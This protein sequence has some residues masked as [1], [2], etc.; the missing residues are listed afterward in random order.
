MASGL[1]ATLSKR[2]ALVTGGASGLGRATAARLARAGAKVVLLDLPSSAGAAVAKEL[3][4]PSSA[5]FAAADVTSEA[6]VRVAGCGGRL[7]SRARA[8]EAGSWSLSGGVGRT[9]EGEKKEGG[10]LSESTA[11]RASPL[12]HAPVL[13]PPPG[14]PRP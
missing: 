1:A 12:T 9:G 7:Q 14:A 5:I 8:P 4:G 3:G 10:L 11:V 13:P 6:D 2:V